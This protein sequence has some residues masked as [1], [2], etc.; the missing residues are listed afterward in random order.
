MLWKGGCVLGL[1]VCGLGLGG[2]GLGLGDCGP[3][4]MAT[5]PP[6]FERARQEAFGDAWKA[7]KSVFGRDTDPDP[8]RGGHD[9][10]TDPRVG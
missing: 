6:M 9:T 3:V 8:A 4:N 2:C 5:W 10:P 1:Q 7:L